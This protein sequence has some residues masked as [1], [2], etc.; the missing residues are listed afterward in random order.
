MIVDPVPIGALRKG[1]TVYVR[2]LKCASTFF[3]DNLL[4]QGWEFTDYYK[5]DWNNDFVFAHIIDPIVRRHKGLAEYIHMC[6][7]AQSYLSSLNLQKI[8][9]S[10]LFLDLHSMPYSVTFNER[11]YDISWIPLGTDHEK[12]VIVTQDILNRKCHTNLTLADWDF[13]LA[14]QTAQGH[15]KKLV[16]LQLKKRWNLSAYSHEKEMNHLWAELYNSIRDPSWP[17]APAATDFYNLPPRIQHE[18]ATLRQSE[19]IEFIAQGDT[20]KLYPN[21]DCFKTNSITAAHSL[22]LQADVNLYNH[23]METFFAL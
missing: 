21:P 1:Y 9:N 8:L 11:L 16:E 3:N 13:D 15:D 17:Q 23:V 2:F 19:G 7:L 14:H 10:C 6:G 4:A 18:I 12:N 5:I 20:W 22:V